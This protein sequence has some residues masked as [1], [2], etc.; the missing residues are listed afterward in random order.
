MEH[1]I[2]SNNSMDDTSN[3]AEDVTLDTE[4]TAEGITVENMYVLEK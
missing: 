3:G 2:N 1:I 4:M